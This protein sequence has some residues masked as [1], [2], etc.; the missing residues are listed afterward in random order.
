MQQPAIGYNTF[1]GNLDYC[2]ILQHFGLEWGEVYW[3]EDQI[4]PYLVQ[5]I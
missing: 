3:Q 5:S 2:Q 4:R 1:R